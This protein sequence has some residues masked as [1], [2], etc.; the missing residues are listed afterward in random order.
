MAVHHGEQVLGAIGVPQRE[1]GAVPGGLGPG[2]PAWGAPSTDSH[3][4]GPVAPR[5][6]IAASKASRRS[7]GTCSR[8]AAWKTTRVWPGGSSPASRGSTSTASPAQIAGGSAATS[9]M[10]CRSSVRWWWFSGHTSASSQSRAPG[11]RTSM[12]L[13]SIPRTLPTLGCLSRSGGGVPP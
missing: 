12:G 3:H 10:A 8:V 4:S 1:G 7:R 9:A 13:R 2:I 11:S 6:L 5:D